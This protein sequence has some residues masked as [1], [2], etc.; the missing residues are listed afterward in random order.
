MPRPALIYCTDPLPSVSAVPML[1][2]Y[3]E[4]ELKLIQIVTHNLKESLTNM[5]VFSLSEVFEVHKA[6]T[7]MA[8]LFN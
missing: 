6:N 4:K 1:H 5:L 8:G 2:S 3:K 7:T